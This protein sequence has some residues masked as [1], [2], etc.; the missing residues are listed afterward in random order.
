MKKIKIKVAI[1]LILLLIFMAAFYEFS[2]KMVTDN[3]PVWNG[4]VVASITN[5]LIGSLFLF[6]N[7]IRKDFFYELKNFKWAF[8]TEVFTFLS[9]ITV[10]L[11]M[12]G[13]P[14]T[15][16]SSIAAIQP[17]AV[18]FYE[19]IAH[20]IFGKM[21]RDNLLLPKLGS[22]ILIVMGVIILSFVGIG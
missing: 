9:A 8:L 7:K 6:N 11:A 17:L 12:V 15:I 18:L 13:L 14:A 21:S 22:I 4:F 5:G 1:W 20:S 19:R 3:L 10:F 2:I 16:V